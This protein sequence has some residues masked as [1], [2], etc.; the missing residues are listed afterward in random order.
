MESRSNEYVE[1]TLL[2]LLTAIDEVV[3]TQDEAFAVLESLLSEGRISLI[4]Q[5]RHSDA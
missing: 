3:A 4:D 1:T 2:E 5:P